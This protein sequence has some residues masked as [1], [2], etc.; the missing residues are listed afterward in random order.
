LG[1]S[2]ENVVY[3]VIPDDLSE[4]ALEP[5]TDSRPAEPGILP[6]KPPVIADQKEEAVQVLPKPK[7]AASFEEIAAMIYRDFDGDL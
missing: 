1:I 2:S 3:K 6:E 4:L 7:K 5:L